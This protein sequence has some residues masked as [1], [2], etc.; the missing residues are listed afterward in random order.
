MWADRPRSAVV[1]IQC[2]YAGAWG[3]IPGVGG[4]D[5]SGQ[6]LCKPL[7]HLTKSVKAGTSPMWEDRMAPT[8]CG[9]IK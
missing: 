6:Y 7:P 4:D 1:S 5:K 8:I 3:S 9:M 2:C